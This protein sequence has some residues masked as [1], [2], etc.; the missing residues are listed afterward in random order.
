MEDHSEGNSAAK[1]KNES[2]AKDNTL[3]RPCHPDEPLTVCLL[4]LAAAMWQA[5]KAKEKKAKAKER[6]AEIKTPAAKKEKAT[7]KKTAE[8]KTPAARK[9]PAA[10]AKTSAKK[11][12]AKDEAGPSATKRKAAAKETPRKVTGLCMY[13]EC[14]AQ[15]ACTVHGRG[16]PKAHHVLGKFSATLMPCSI[17]FHMQLDGAESADPFDVSFTNQQRY[18]I[19]RPSNTVVHANDGN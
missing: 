7:E 18:R 10:K 6:A 1:K 17:I 12:P 19:F 16:R 4:R 8:E 15:E 3:Q 5:E 13:P 2:T 9:E 14:I 11:A